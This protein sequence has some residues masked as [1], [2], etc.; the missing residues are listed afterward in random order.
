M[1]AIDHAPT[2]GHDHKE[3]YQHGCAET[4]DEERCC[5]VGGALA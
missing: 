1:A 2:R 3:V 5:E 4:R